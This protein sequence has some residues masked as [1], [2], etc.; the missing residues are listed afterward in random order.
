MAMNRFMISMSEEDIECFEAG[1][2]AAGMSKS[3]YIRLL[4]AE[5]DNRVPG[6][7]KYQDVIKGMAEMNTLIKQV[8]L[9]KN[10]DEST[11]LILLERLDKMSEQLARLR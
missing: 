4:I 6:F 11:K 1:R 8:V 7:L 5:H 10:V 2:E 9:G 3:A